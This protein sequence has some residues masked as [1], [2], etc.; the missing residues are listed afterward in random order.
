M[1]GFYGE[2]TTYLFQIAGEACEGWADWTLEKN[3]EN[4]GGIERSSEQGQIMT[5]ITKG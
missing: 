2:L 3:C 4:T 1:Q 5:F